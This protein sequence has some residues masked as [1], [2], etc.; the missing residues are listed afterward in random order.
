M[1]KQLSRRTFLRTSAVSA[2]GVMALGAKAVVAEEAGV[3]TPGTYSATT[4]GI[5]NV[6][7]TMT[8]DAEKITDVVIDVANETAGYGKTIDGSMA[9]AILEAQS[10]E[11]DAVSGVTITSDAIKLA[12]ENCIAQAKGEVV[13]ALVAEAA[14]VEDWRTAPEAITEFAAEYTADVVI[15]GGGQAGTPAAR[16]A[17]EAGASVI[18]LESQTEEGMS[19]RGGGQ[20]GHINSEFLASKGIPK[21]DI[22]EFVTDWQLRTNNRSRC[23]LIMKYAQNSGVCFD[24]MS[25]S[26]IC[27][28]STGQTSMRRMTCLCPPDCRSTNSC[29][30]R[31]WKRTRRSRR[32]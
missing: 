24:W 21:V 3:Y 27:C 14:P 4:K 18:V 28:C 32:R 23:G 9:K 10:A 15:V 7:V 5:G 31:V 19:F 20:I 2:L 1:A 16:A 12:A 6:T 17:I 25:D 22:Q 30:G 11:I 8:F 29:S 13:V 26:F